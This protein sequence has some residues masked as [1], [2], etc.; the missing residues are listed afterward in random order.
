MM[1]VVAVVDTLDDE[2]RDL[3]VGEI[4]V[5]L[6]LLVSAQFVLTRSSRHT[7]TIPFVSH[8]LF[9]CLPAPC[10]THPM[11]HTRLTLKVCTRR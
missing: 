1:L 2:P 4:V 9:V 3:Y 7:R 5:V 10:Y 6:L 8:A 11:L